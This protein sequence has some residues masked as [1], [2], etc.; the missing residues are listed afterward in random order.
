MIYLDLNSNQVGITM[1]RKSLSYMHI[2]VV[3]KIRD[4]SFIN[5]TYE[6]SN[7]SSPYFYLL[8][9]QI[10]KRFDTGIRRPFI[11]ISLIYKTPKQQSEVYGTG[12]FPAHADKHKY[13]FR[14]LP[15]QLGEAFTRHNGSCWCYVNTRINTE[16]SF[17]FYKKAHKYCLF[18]VIK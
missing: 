6:E 2:K 18:Y 9:F 8:I 5:G 11:Y 4:C 12:W 14:E 10:F 1:Y 13:W 7:P 3:P 15:S 16:I 17:Y